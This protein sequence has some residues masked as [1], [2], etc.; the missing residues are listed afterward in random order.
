MSSWTLKQNYFVAGVGLAA[1][2]FSLAACL[3]GCTV[4]PN[5]RRP[6]APVPAIWDV[7]E[8][9]RESAPKDLIPKGEWWTVFY[10][11]ELSTLEKQAIDAN[12][13]I[14]ESIGRLEQARATAAVQISTLFPTLG[15][16]PGTTTPTV[17]RQGLS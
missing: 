14:K 17:E 15:L 3:A 12:Q 5:Y 2:S 6:I 11:D 1:G 13:T 7:Q 4:G 16:S 8:P 9:W 10:E